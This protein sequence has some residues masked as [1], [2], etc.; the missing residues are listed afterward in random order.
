MARAFLDTNVLVYAFTHDTRADA[1][2]AVLARRCETSVQVLNEFANV[3]RRKLRMGWDELA[4]ALAAVRALCSAIHPVDLEVHQRAME[5][6]ERYALSV[7]DALIVASARKAGCAVLYSGNMKDG[8]QIDGAL[9]IFNPFAGAL[10]RL[11]WLPLPPGRPA[12][13][14]KCPLR[15]R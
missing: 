10:I 6:A 1:A 13:A 3:A 5:F 2:E 14:G 15:A 8:L 4:E 7:Y 12:R 11:G 9:R